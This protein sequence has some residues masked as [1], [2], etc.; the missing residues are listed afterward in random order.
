MSDKMLT[1]EEWQ[2]DLGLGGMPLRGAF[3]KARQGMISSE[4]AVVIPP[5]SEWPKY[6]DCVAL[7][8]YNEHVGIDEGE[9]AIKLI[10]R[11]KPVW[12]PK[13]G[14]AVF[15][16]DALEPNGVWVAKVLRVISGNEVFIVCNDG[17]ESHWGISRLKP[18]H[19]DHIGKPWDEIPGGV[20]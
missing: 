2:S 5:V 12:T 15:A 8:W 17:D 16:L 18:F 3:E 1:Y 13:V 4:N 11:P 7:F 14:E 10:P 6:A 19:P 9:T 20:E